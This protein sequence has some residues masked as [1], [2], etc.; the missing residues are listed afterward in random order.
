VSLRKGHA[1]EYL[2]EVSRLRDT[3][4]TEALLA[5]RNALVARAEEMRTELVGLL[6][7][8]VDNRCDATPSGLYDAARFLEVL[9]DPRITLVGEAL[10]EQLRN[11]VTEKRAL[12]ALLDRQ[13]GVV[14]DES[15][16]REL[17][18]RLHTLR[19][20]YE[21]ARNALQLVSPRQEDSAAVSDDEADVELDDAVVDEEREHL[22]EQMQS[23]LGA[24]V[25]AREELYRVS[26]KQ[27]QDAHRNRL[28]AVRSVK[29]ARAADVR[30]AGDNVLTTDA[31]LV[32]AKANLRALV[33]EKHRFLRRWLI[34]YPLF[35]LLGLFGLIVV[36]LATDIVPDPSTIT[37]NIAPGGVFIL[38]VALVYLFFV[39]LKYT[40]DLGKQMTDVREEIVRLE[41]DL[42]A[43]TARYLQQQ[44]RAL[45]F[46]FDVAAW[47]TLNETVDTVIDTAS[48]R[49]N[50]LEETIEWLTELRSNYARRRDEIVPSS[51]AMRRP[52]LSAD[53][54]D[55][56]YETSVGN[57][58]SE[59]IAFG[60]KHAP[61]SLVRKLDPSELT[62]RLDTV[63]HARFA[64]L[65][66]L[67]IDDVLYR[68][69]E[70]LP[71]ETTANVF[72]LLKD[73]AETLVAVRETDASRENVTQY[74]VTIW[75][76]DGDH[77]ETFDKLRSFWRIATAHTS[78]D[79]QS[80]RVLSRCL[81]FPAH[82]ISKIEYYKSCY[83]K[84][85]DRVAADLPDLIPEVLSL[86]PNV[87][88]AYESL[89]VAIALGIVTKQKGEYV[90]GD[91]AATK[92]GVNRFSIATKLGAEYA[93]RSSNA[94]LDK[95]VTKRR[96]QDENAT[97]EA[98][99]RFL[100]DASDLDSRERSILE[101]VQRRLVPIR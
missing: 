15:P 84:N 82:S 97:Y 61:R 48:R 89:L 93:W 49:R 24:I 73:V 46:E 52:V 28:E 86:A 33:E 36:L 72:H 9:V 101:A 68:E 58:E 85:A 55:A 56:F 31:S 6:D 95:K 5:A 7:A 2:T 87:R 19:S 99:T 94:W 77:S 81:H 18:E 88:R 3:F 37:S 63:T 96:T 40:N 91:P 21:A 70:L 20:D 10:S 16:A 54:I 90:L 79:P 14:V 1:G 32:S 22:E 25:S 35:G 12:A 42:E 34:T 4:E 41:S 59:A 80:I 45:R 75:T 64:R 11:L 26:I 100:R 65:E 62:T 8:E 74:D 76:A 66:K 47:Q 51:S 92:L 71:Q 27:D 53:D 30:N 13:L 44:E 60:E 38:V 39:W 69:P 29:E 23:A 78:E 98:I 50:E 83:E 57:A 67:S 43:D 17:L